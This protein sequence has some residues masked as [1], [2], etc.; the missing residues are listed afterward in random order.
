MYQMYSV[1]QKRKAVAQTEDLRLIVKVWL[2][3][4]FGPIFF[5]FVCRQKSFNI[6]LLPRWPGFNSHVRPLYFISFY[7]VLFSLAVLALLLFR[8][9]G[10]DCGLGSLKAQIITRITSPIPWVLKT[11]ILFSD[12]NWTTS[13]DPNYIK[14]FST[15]ECICVSKY[16]S[17]K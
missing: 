13:I 12:S 3:L 17:E 2:K 15:W 11:S 7:H 5:L 8:G 10:I 9:F 14:H 1:M 4:C 6:A 16:M